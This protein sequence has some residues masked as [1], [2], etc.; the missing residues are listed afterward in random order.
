MTIINMEEFSKDAKEKFGDKVSWNLLR[1]NEE[2]LKVLNDSLKSNL[3]Q[4]DFDD[5]GPQVWV[6]GNKC[7]N[8]GAELW[9]IFGYF[10]WSISHGEGICGNCREVDFRFYH[11]IGKDR[12]RIEILSLIGF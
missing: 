12:I 7:P 10:E 9:G 4:K 8:C 2:S 3:T 6:I 1:V 11:Y 5:Y